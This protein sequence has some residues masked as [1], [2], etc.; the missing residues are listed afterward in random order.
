[1][2]WNAG[3][4]CSV[5]RLLLA[6]PGMEFVQGQATLEY[7]AALYPDNCAVGFHVVHHRTKAELCF[8]CVR[9]A[10]LLTACG[11]IVTMEGACQ[12]CA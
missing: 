9:A 1:M 10:V 12:D 4:R 3:V 8:S 11:V 2:T 5:I 6:A 7:C